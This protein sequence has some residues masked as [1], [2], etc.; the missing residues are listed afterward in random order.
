[1][2]AYAIR[3]ILI[4]IPTLIGI[5]LITF[6]LVRV[7]GDPARFV[8][9]DTAPPSAI[10]AFRAEHGLDKPLPV[11]FVN[12][13]AG[14][15]RGDLGTSLRYQQ[16][17]LTLFAERLPATIQ[18]GLSAYILALLVGV[19]VGVY[20][21]LRAG[22]PLDKVIRVSVLF[23]QAVPGFYLGLVLIIVVAVGLGWLPT[24]GRGG[25]SHLVLPTIT[26]ASYLVAFSVRFTRSVMLDV[27]HHDYIRTARAKGVA[28]GAV[29]RRHALRNALIPLVTV[30]ALQSS[31]VFS[32]AVVTETVF[33]WPGIGR[34]ALQAISTRDFPV[35]QGTVLILT[36]FVVLVNLI[37]DL[38][39]AY[40]DPRIRYS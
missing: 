1:M 40:L 3:R 21:A 6:L 26:L 2:L 19:S 37:V 7:T 9:G 4:A 20:S 10:E 23:G 36:A 39:Y 30:L 33:S 14:V 25:L 32:G 24:G 15:A 31:V 35:I 28:E 22:S 18:L 11:Q 29:I 38:A 17:V 27:L 12:Y 16:P 8:L 34:F 5:T 13:L